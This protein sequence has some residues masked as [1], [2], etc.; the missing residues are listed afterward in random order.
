MSPSLR[1]DLLQAFGLLPD[2]SIASPKMTAAVLN[3]SDRTLRR[4]P[5][6]PRIQL[7]AQ[8]FGFRV[9]T[10]RQ[11]IRGQFTRAA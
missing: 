2:D 8:R 4:S 1:A 3:I 9:G 10:I 11:L 5:P 7:T 6:I